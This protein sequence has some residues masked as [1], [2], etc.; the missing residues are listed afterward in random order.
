MPIITNLYFLKITVGCENMITEFVLH[1]NK[2]KLIFLHCK[3]QNSLFHM[4]TL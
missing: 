3:H 4:A 1:R 2:F